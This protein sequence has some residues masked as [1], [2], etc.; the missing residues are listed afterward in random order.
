MFEEDKYMNEFDRMVKSI[1]DEGREEVPAGVWEAVSE[2]LDKAARGKTVVLWWR[3]A[4]AG[5]AVA[6]AVAIAVIFNIRPEADLVPEAGDSGLIA[7]VEPETAAEEDI[8]LIPDAVAELTQ[9]R[10]PA[11]RSIIPQTASEAM[12]AE[13]MEQE[14]EEDVIIPQEAAPVKE[15][16]SID[17]TKE[18]KTGKEA[19]AEYFPEDWGEDTPKTRNI[20]FTLS[21]LA[22][23]NQTQSRNRIGPMKAPSITSAPKE[24]GISETST[25]STYGLPV[26]F[27]A[28]VKIG[29]SPRWSVG[30]GANYTLLA[31]QFYGKY[32][33]VD[34]NGSIEKATSSDIRN[35]Q[36]FIG[37]PVNAYFDIVNQDR[38]NLYAYA[39]GT[40]EKCVSDNYNVLST[41]I[42]HRE[43]TKGVQLSANAGIGVEFMLGK[44]LGLYIDPSVRYYFDCDQPKSI[45]TEQ[46]LMFGF[47]MGLRARL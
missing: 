2:G 45:R 21:G 7:V 9:D 10:H 41:A 14:S 32:I 20:S 33:K 19:P 42:Q 15:V 36:H 22:S 47:E 6:A 11:V 38:I 46:P 24:T 25:N 13:M 4:A 30:V 31:R 26:S 35:T 18:E 37:I 44:H 29:L 17:K 3:R 40:V 8:T 12:D 23:T 28:G 39:G 5:V 16:P 27:G 1:L 43:K 34:D